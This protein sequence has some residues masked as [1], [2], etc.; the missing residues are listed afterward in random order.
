MV[1]VGN[2][3]TAKTTVARL[4]AKALAALDMLSTGQLVE[5]TRADLIGQY[6]GHTA[7]RVVNAVERALGGVLF[8]DEAYALVSRAGTHDFGDEA[9]ATLLKLMEDHRGD[10]VVIAAGYP[11]PIE[12]FLEANPGLSSRFA[13]TIRFDENDDDELVAIFSS[14]VSKAGMNLNDGGAEAL[15]WSMR[16]LTRLESFGNGRTMRTLFERALAAQAERLHDLPE[17]TEIELRSIDV[18]DVQAAVSEIAGEAEK[19][20]VTTPPLA[21]ARQKRE[22]RSRW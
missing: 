3:G 13:R 16:R 9:I 20:V 2:P 18:S 14:M 5:V 21:S 17:V 11:A 15:Q 22:T 8:I 12:R 19:T 6:I 4:F 1:F 7:P 10:F